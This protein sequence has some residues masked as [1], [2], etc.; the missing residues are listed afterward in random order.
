MGML[1]DLRAKKAA[2]D[3]AAGGTPPPAPAIN[4]PPGQPS[5][6]AAAVGAQVASTPPPAAAIPA[7]APAQVAKAKAA[8]KTDMANR[9]AIANRLGLALLDFADY[10]RG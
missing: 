5:P 6:V 7:D 4:P 9:D 3:L 2:A 10:L 1:E 8:R